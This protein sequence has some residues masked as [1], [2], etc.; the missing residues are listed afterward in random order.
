MPR[1]LGGIYEA[2]VT[3]GCRNGVTPR[4]AAAVLAALTLHRARE[5]LLAC[6]LTVDVLDPLLRTG[7]VT[8]ETGC[9]AEA[10][11]CTVE[12]IQVE[13]RHAHQHV[14]FAFRLDILFQ[15]GF[16]GLQRV[17][18]LRQPRVLLREA[19]VEFRIV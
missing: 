16:G 19:Q 15:G 8:L 5:L 9:G 2:G 6:L 13:L 3:A 1:S 7:R 17:L 11:A 18:P 12:A 4:A 14:G 10:A